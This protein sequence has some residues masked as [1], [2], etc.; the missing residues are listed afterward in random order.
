VA[1]GEAPGAV[2]LVLA[3]ELVTL[4]GMVARRGSVAHFR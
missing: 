4:G 1:P 2:A 3:A